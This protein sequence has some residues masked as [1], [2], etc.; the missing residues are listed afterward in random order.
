MFTIQDDIF[1]CLEEN[2]FTINAFKSFQMWMYGSRDWLAWALAQARRSQALEIEGWS[3]LAS[4]TSDQLTQ[5]M[6]FYWFA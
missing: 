3:H 2:R 1:S 5:N 6:L 4:T